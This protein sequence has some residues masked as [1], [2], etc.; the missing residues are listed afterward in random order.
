MINMMEAVCDDL[1]RMFRGYTLPNKAGVL[2][3]VRI[4]AQ[5]MPQPSGITFDDK[6]TGLKNYTGEDFEQNFPGIIV[7]LGDMTDQEEQRL[8]MNR[9]SVKL[10]CGVYDA[11]PVCNGW[12]DVAGMMEKIRQEWLKERVI[13]R[14]FR[15]EMPLVT[16]LVEADTW[17]VYFGEMEVM[18]ETGRV[19]RGVDYVYR[20]YVSNG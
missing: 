6:N 7:K 9:V 18:F 12:R 2:Q 10:L 3:E 15:I 4:F 16:R 11:N 13:A 5:Y 8:D 20:G 19:G 14:R 1:R 17:P